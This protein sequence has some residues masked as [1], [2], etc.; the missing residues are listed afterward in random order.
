MRKTNRATRREGPAQFPRLKALHSQIRRNKR[1]MGKWLHIAPGK[2]VVHHRVAYKHDLGNL[3]LAPLC[4]THNYFPERSTHKRGQIVAM[5]R[6]ANP[7]HH[8][9]SERGLRIE[10]GLDTEDATRGQIDDKSE[11]RSRAQIRS[12]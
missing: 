11:K 2:Q 9:R 12:E 6:R 5:E 8:I 7:I 1:R 3:L 4:E 10:L